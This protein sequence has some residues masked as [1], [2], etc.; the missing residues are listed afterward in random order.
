MSSSSSSSS[1]LLP[2][3]LLHRASRRLESAAPTLAT[4][5]SAWQNNSRG[6]ATQ[7]DSSSSSER[8]ED[9]RRRRISST[10]TSTSTSSSSP[11]PS[12]P[13]PSY[14]PLSPFQRAALALAASVGAALDPKRADLVA[15]AGEATGS[16]A[17]AA[18]ARRMAASAFGRRMLAERPRVGDGTLETARR[19][20]PGTFGEAYALFMD[21]RGFRP[22]ERP[23]VRF[24][25]GMTTEEEVGRR[26]AGIGDD[27]ARSSS[28]SPSSSFSLPPDAAA[29]AATRSRECHDFW[30]VL[31]GCPTTVLGE[32]SLKALEFS[33]L[34]LPSAAAAVAA[35][36]WRLKPADRRRL[37]TQLLPWAA[38]AGARSADLMCLFYEEHLDE[39]LWELRGRWRIEPAPRR[40]GEPSAAWLREGTGGWGDL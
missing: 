5:S 6:L 32:L 8:R 11:T 38:R 35:A 15:A 10:S 33:Q 24:V 36:S 19:C 3:L 22:S 7:A 9:D 31:F 29:F 39:D 17:F 4:F 13:Y 1:S 34:G 16:R 23:P 2:L 20:G 14:V 28:S 18:A 27:E 30:H 40:E 26:A 21:R 25:E 12:L 37:Y